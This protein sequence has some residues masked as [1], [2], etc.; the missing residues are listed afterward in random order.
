VLEKPRGT[1]DTLTIPAT[2]RGATVPEEVNP[3]DAAVGPDRRTFVKRLIIGTAFAA[4]VVASFKMSGIGAVFGDTAGATTAMSNSN[5]AGSKYPTL[6]G[7]FFFPVGG[8]THSFSGPPPVTLVVQPNTFYPSGQQV[9]VYRGN[10]SQLQPLLP[11]GYTARSGVAAVWNGPDVTQ[12]VSLTVNDPVVQT[13]DEIFEVIGSTTQPFTGAVGPNTW[14]VLFTED[15]SF[16]VA[17]PPEAPPEEPPPTTP[18]S[19]GAAAPTA[20]VA[21]PTTTG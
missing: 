9:F 18:D 21:E 5:S 16:V 7:S 6:I 12:D 14:S 10:L 13:G 19:G 2:L 11:A 3:V 4:P 8:G 20:V 17:T 1:V 15:P